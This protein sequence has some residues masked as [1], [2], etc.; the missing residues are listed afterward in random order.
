MKTRL[1]GLIAVML[2]MTASDS[3]PVDGQQQKTAGNRGV[4]G[5]A[6][7]DAPIAP[8]PKP[9][10]DAK[11]SA[12][13]R[14]NIVLIIADDQ[15]WTDFGFMGHKLVKTPAIDALAAQSARFDHGYVPTSLCRASLATLLTGQYAHQHCICFNDP[16]KG[17]GREEAHP[18]IARSPALPRILSTVGYKS[19]QTG[20]F[21]EGHYANAGFTDG[22]TVKG[23]HGDTGLAIGR[24]TMEPIEKFLDRTGDAPFFL[25]YA[26]MLPHTP[27]NPP[28]KYL[29]EYA[30]KG[31]DKATQA[32]YATIR[33]FD[34]SVAA[35]LKML[36]DRKLSE[37]TAILFIVDNGWAV[38]LA[39]ERT[40]YGVRS[41]NSPFDG[42]LRTPVLVRWPGRTQP[43]IHEDLVSSID[44]VPTLLDIAGL[45]YATKGLPGL[46]LLGVSTGKSA[47]LD[48]DTL[49]GELYLHTATKLGDPQ[50]D[51]TYRWIRRG[52]W[53]LIRPSDVARRSAVTPIGGDPLNRVINP[54][55]GPFLFDLRHD[56]HETK[57][58]AND[59]SKAGLVKELS[60]ALATWVAD[61]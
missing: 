61:Q 39:G 22:M 19:F 8:A 21:W 37:E 47:K 31:L 45:D 15:A 55:D 1:A 34:D 57:N 7:V 17:I 38:P 49:Y 28:Q 18:F 29:D 9:T 56:P 51:M 14:P 25:W 20:K 26:P 32:Y 53:K 50:A 13:K 10:E 30:E 36:D 11:P 44:V 48:R 35:L 24:T 54:T 3:R 59:P 46:S 16:P 33:W 43:G 60:E 2:L 52:D 42:G 6:D 12:K 58:L 27:H 4:S 41:K 40:A 23:R 5:K